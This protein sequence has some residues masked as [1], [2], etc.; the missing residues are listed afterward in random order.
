[1][2]SVKKSILD[3]AKSAADR[4]SPLFA[5]ASAPLFSNTFTTSTSPLPAAR[6]TAGTVYTLDIEPEMVEMTRGR[7]AE[8]AFHN[9]RVEQRDFVAEGTG[10]PDES[11]YYAMLFNILHCE[12]PVALLREAWRT[13]AH[14]GLLGVIHWNHDPTTPRGPD[15]DIRPRPQQC[16]RWAE[17]AGFVATAEGVIDLPPY[18]W[19]LALRRPAAG[20][21]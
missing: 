2:F 9:V 16:V 14:G 15:L 5:L 4:T 6:I 8:A 11:A 21:R 12:Q 20:Q 7:A 13:V 17:E 10:R 19:G 3:R 18:H 1:M